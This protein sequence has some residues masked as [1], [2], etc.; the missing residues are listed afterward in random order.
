MT[1]TPVDLLVDGEGS[2]GREVRSYELAYIE[3]FSSYRETLT[4]KY[5]VEQ[6][7]VLRRVPHVGDIERQAAMLLEEY[8][9]LKNTEPSGS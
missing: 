5:G 9:R 4:M 1:F 7:R 3:A 8:K 6:V 2:A